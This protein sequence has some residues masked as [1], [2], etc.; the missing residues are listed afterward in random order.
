VNTWRVKFHTGPLDVQ[1]LAV[2]AAADEGISDVHLGTEHIYFTILAGDVLD[3]DARIRRAVGSSVKVTT[4][5]ISEEEEYA[6]SA[7]TNGCGYCG[8]CS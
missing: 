2:K 3:C 7:C 4:W 1:R 8:R 5:R 6:G